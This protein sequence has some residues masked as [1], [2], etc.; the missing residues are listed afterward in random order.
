MFEPKV[1]YNDCVPALTRFGSMN[2]NAIYGERQMPG[3]L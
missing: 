2:M 1:E 3:G